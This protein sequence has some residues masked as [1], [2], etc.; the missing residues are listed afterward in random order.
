MG[1]HILIVDDEPIIRH[2]L[3]AHFS[4]R[5][6][7]CQI[8][9][10]GLAALTILGQGKIKVMVTD[11]EMPGMDGLH[12]IRTMRA[13]GFITR[14]VVITGYA[15][16]GNLTACLRE[17]AVA[18]VPKPL[19]DMQLLDRAVDQAIEQLD[20]WSKQMHAIARMRPLESTGALERRSDHVS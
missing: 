1:T 18:L 5:G 2:L 16:V 14:S 7:H 19:H 9:G 11:L 15:S 20:S 10:D 12:L 4:S 17:G 6:F 8:A 3:E 13:R